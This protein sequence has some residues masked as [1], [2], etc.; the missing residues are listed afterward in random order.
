MKLNM[1][2]ILREGNMLKMQSTQLYK[3]DLFD[4][5]LY[6]YVDT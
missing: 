6:A 4:I 3:L 2:N 1:C 5:Y